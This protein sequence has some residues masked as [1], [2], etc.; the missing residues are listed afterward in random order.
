MQKQIPFGDDNKKNETGNDG[1]GWIRV[2]G[3]GQFFSIVDASTELR[4]VSD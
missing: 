2:F 1:V 3:N 4:R